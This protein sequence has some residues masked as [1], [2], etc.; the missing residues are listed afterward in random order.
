M[1]RR[2]TTTVSSVLVLLA[3]LD[4]TGPVSARGCSS[5]KDCNTIVVDGKTIVTSNDQ[6]CRNVDPPRCM[7]IIEYLESCW[8]ILPT[9]KPRSIPSWSTRPQTW[10]RTLAWT[11]THAWTRTLAWTRPQAWTR[12]QAWT[13]WTDPTGNYG[14][15][16][17][18]SS[19]TLIV[20]LLVIFVA[21]PLPIV[22]YCRYGRSRRSA[23]QA[24]Q[25]FTSQSDTGQREARN[26]P[27]HHV[28]TVVDHTTTT[29][30]QSMPDAWSLSDELPSYEDVCNPALS[31]VVAPPPQYDQLSDDMPP[32]PRYEDVVNNVV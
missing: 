32:P 24:S 22:L 4:C 31:S 14:S 30:P 23:Q 15:S 20:V 29:V 13:V 11:R 2:T 7:E 27:S 5:H 12:T 21:I 10:T 3:V 6:C 25:G 8:N 17:S 19:T 16:S 26:Q 1:F 18:S 9:A 28:I